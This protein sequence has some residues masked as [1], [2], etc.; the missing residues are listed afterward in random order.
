[1]N[2]CQV[3]PPEQQ[4][5]RLKD[6]VYQCIGDLSPN[7][8]SK[9]VYISTIEPLLINFVL[10]DFRSP[11]PLLRST[12]CWLFDVYSSYKFSQDIYYQQIIQE[13]ITVLLLY[14]ILLIYL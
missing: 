2:R 9:T 12:A 13:L 4:D 6:A 11:Y 14:I 1:M 5:F 7:L 8:M 3:V 10:P